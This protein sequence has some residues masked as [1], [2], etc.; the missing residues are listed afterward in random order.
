MIVTFLILLGALLVIVILA[1]I[2]DYFK[3]KKKEHDI[4]E[5]EC[6]VKMMFEEGYLEGL[7][8]SE[9]IKLSEIE[10]IKLNT[11][12]YIDAKLGKINFR[13]YTH[14]EGLRID[15]IRATSKTLISK[16]Y[17]KV[18]LAIKM[19]NSKYLKDLGSRLIKK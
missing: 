13:L 6:P 14:D 11:I 18:E 19:H 5:N 15:H 4:L 10:Y 7:L 16:F 1:S 3:E 9:E 17:D 12:S 8:D 2:N